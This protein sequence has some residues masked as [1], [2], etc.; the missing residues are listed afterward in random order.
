MTDHH[1]KVVIDGLWQ[2]IK[3]LHKALA[4]TSPTMEWFFDIAPPEHELKA[5]ERLDAFHATLRACDELVAPIRKIMEE[6]KS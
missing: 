3:I 6:E 1:D 2:T 4:A 5:A